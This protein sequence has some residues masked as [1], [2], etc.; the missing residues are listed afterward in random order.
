MIVV[1]GATGQLGRDVVRHLL[2][3]VVPERIGVSVRDP[4]A[5]TALA[6]RGVRVRRGDFAEPES[7][8]AAF[9]GAEI[10][11][12]I[13]SNAAAYGGD[14]LQQHR[15]AFKA[16]AKAG[17]GHV[18]YTSHLGAGHESAFPP[19]RHHAATEDMLADLLTGSATRWTALRHGF[20]ADTAIQTV[21]TALDEGAVRLPADGPV[22]WTA[23]ADLAVADAE[24]LAQIDGGS[25]EWDGVSA[26]LAAAE[27]LDASGL[28]QIAATFT[29]RDVPREVLTDDQ[30]RARFTGLGMPDSAVELTLGIYQAAR[31][32]E[33]AATGPD[34]ERL[35]GRR[36]TSVLDAFEASRPDEQ[37]G[38]T[39]HPG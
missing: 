33:L 19:C 11:L 34:L 23:R 26:P 6:E 18:V 2:T 3:L 31:A 20:Y 15:D 1:T 25:Q 12:L 37:A 5:A 38:Q 27:T 13:S 35:L 7:L 24:I 9:E 8:S 14:P 36:P 16:A 17:V 30:A 29:G 39:D 10:L 28:A 4:Q 21:T 32:G 22:S